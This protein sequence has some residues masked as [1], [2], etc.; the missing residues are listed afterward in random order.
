MNNQDTQLT[1][2]KGYNAKIKMIFSDPI[3][4]T[5]PVPHK[6]INIST[7]YPDGTTGPLIIPFS[8]LYSFGVNIN[9]DPADKDKPEGERRITGYVFPLCL[10]GRDGIPSAEEKMTDE[11][12]DSIVDNCIE[13]L[14]DVKEEIDLAELTRND[15]TKQK[16]GLHPYYWKKEKIPNPKKPGSTI[17][18]KVEGRGPTLY[19]KLIYSKKNDKFG[20]FLYDPND[21]LLEVTD[22]FGKHCYAE[23]AVKIE[24]IFIGGLGPKLQIKLYEAN[25]EPANSGTKRLLGRP[26]SVSGV[27]TAKDDQKSAASI[28]GGDESDGENG[29]LNGSV[30]DES[31]EKE[32]EPVVAKPVRRVVKRLV[33]TRVTAKV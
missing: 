30:I 32:E 27:L 17:T 5:N 31:P 23:A 4:N 19:A 10:W 8:K 21:N 14:L 24:S 9:Y 28:L 18:R 22:W 12:I 2:S 33:K 7:L 13:H 16:G 11:C 25:V 3:N 29:S 15:L 20:S 1:P 6:R 26:K